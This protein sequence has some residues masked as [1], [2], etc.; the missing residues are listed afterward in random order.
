VLDLLREIYERLTSGGSTEEQ[1]VQ[2]GI[3][4]AG[5]N[6]GDRVLQLLKVIILARLLSPEAFGLLGIALLVVAALRQF[7]AIGFDAALVQHRD[8]NV[9]EYLNTVWVMKMV[10]WL[11][12]AA[13]AVPAAPY[14]ARFFSEPQAAPLIMTVAIANLLL[15]I[16]NPGVVY[17]R[18]NLNF[19]KEFIYTMSGRSVD[20]ILAVA[21]AVVYQSVWALVLGIVAMNLMKVAS[22]YLIHEFRPS[23]EF[24][25]EYAN[26]M[27]NFG[28]WILLSGILAFLLTEGDDGFVGWFFSATAL[29]FYQLGYRYSNA[30]A[31]EVTQVINRVAFPTFSRVQGNIKKLR[32]GFLRV[33][34]VTMVISLPMSLGIVAVAPQFVIV[35]LGEQWR[36]MIPLMQALAIWGGMRSFSKIPPAVFKAVGK[37]EY[38]TY[39]LSIKV[40]V[41]ALAIYPAAEYFGVIGVTYV[42][43]GQGII[44]EPIRAYLALSLTETNVSELF[45]PILYPAVGSLGMFSVVT[46]INRVVFTGT[47]IIEL[48]VLITL[49]TVI[50]GGIMYLIEQMTSY[51]FTGIYDSVR[52]AV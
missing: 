23:L 33:I 29:G 39:T 35:V 24:N 51:E 16:Q 37:P 25:L 2:S 9:D 13:I 14:I 43:I 8:E 4:V 18:K 40:A 45:S 52:Q 7:S 11:L 30:P 27:F 22:S 36:P 10:R 1:A 3:W 42:I 15:A 44:S 34:R 6:V 38:D 12:I 48:I 50:Y 28:K 41:I 5:I 19:H 32:N 49:G 20:L 17:F 21:I 31:T 26:E 46:T 47:G